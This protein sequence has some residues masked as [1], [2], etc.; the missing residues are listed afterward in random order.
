MRRLKNL[1]RYYQVTIYIYIEVKYLIEL[2][3]IFFQSLFNS[4]VLLGF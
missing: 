1:L 3:S 4:L 2:F